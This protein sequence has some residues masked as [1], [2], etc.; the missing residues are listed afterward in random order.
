V[1]PVLLAV[2]LAAPTLAFAQVARVTGV[3]RDAAGPVLA[4]AEVRALSI[5]GPDTVVAARTLTDATGAFTLRVNGELP[6]LTFVVRRLGYHPEALPA[7]ALREGGPVDVALQRLPRV[8]ATVTVRGSNCIRDLNTSTNPAAQLWRQALEAADVKQTVLRQYTWRSEERWTRRKG[9]LS[10]EP[11][12]DT[13]IVGDDTN[14]SI[15]PTPTRPQNP[16][17]FGRATRGRIQLEAGGVDNVFD[18]AFL[19]EYCPYEDVFAD[20]AGLVGV[21]F[22]PRRPNKRQVQVQG[23]VLFDETTGI[24]RSLGYRFYAGERLLGVSTV[25]IADEL[26][27]GTGFPLDVEQVLEVL[28]PRDGKVLTRLDRRMTRT[29][30][31]RR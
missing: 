18:P 29:N 21:G 12:S 26:I 15:S 17:Y 10:V 27:E 31:R 24:P 2:L 4:L 28:D 16:T 23:E 7:S 9:N 8:L 20:G 11:W 5:R 30:F 14:Q 25:V 3:V 22:G 6:A 1:R 19:S 13:V